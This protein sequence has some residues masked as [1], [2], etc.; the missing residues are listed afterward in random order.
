MRAR[1]ETAYGE[2]TAGEQL[3]KAEGRMRDGGV[4]PLEQ[5]PEAW[6]VRGKASHLLNRRGMAPAA[7]GLRREAYWK[8]VEDE[9]DPVCLTGGWCKGG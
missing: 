6:A 3:G 2:A 1:L 5:R 4:T 9:L 7:V 8:L